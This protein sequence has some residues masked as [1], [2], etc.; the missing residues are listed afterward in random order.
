MEVPFLFPNQN[1][2]VRPPSPKRRTRPRVCALN[3]ALRA[4]GRVKLPSRESLRLCAE[5]YLPAQTTLLIS[6]SLSPPATLPFQQHQTSQQHPGAPLAHPQD[7]HLTPKPM[8]I[9]G[10]QLFSSSRMKLKV[11]PGRE[12]PFGSSVHREG[13][14]FP[15]VRTVPCSAG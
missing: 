6:L 13:R 10:L 1:S 2:P 11:N 5:G 15:R 12:E 9:P 7:S 3:L 4:S 14:K 8:T